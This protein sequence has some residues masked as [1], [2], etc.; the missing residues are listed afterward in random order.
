MPKDGDERNHSDAQRLP[1]ERIQERNSLPSTN[2]IEQAL[3][4]LSPEKK[5]ELYEKAADEALGLQKLST[6]MEIERRNV[7]EKTRSHIDAMH[8]ISASDDLNKRNPLK[9]HKIETYVSTETGHRR[10]E[11]S[12]GPRCFV[13]TVCFGETSEE[14]RYLRSYRDEVLKKSRL[15]R[16]FIHW[17][18]K[19]GPQLASMAQNYRWVR[20]IA[21][22]LIR[23][24]LITLKSAAFNR[25][26]NRAI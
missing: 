10:I 11:S 20:L 13:A 12:S 23:L 6:Q 3:T 19:Q 1:A 14:V 9:S 18:Y 24:T 25:K 7:D 5:Q 22:A 26:R 15:G 8:T 21:T 17:Y 16:R 2:L 4:N